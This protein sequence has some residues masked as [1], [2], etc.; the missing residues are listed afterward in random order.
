MSGPVTASI[1]PLTVLLM[2]LAP[3]G[4]GLVRRS[5]VCNVLDLSTIIK[6]STIFSFFFFFFFQDFCRYLFHQNLPKG[7][8]INL[9]N[10]VKKK[11]NFLDIDISLE[12]REDLNL[13]T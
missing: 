5:Q 10:Y 8:E 13:N 11:E 2:S 9:L 1:S 3:L 4:T 6:N 12:E 7:F